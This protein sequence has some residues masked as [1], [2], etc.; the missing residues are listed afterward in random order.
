MT[1][2]ELIKHWRER[3][4]ELLGPGFSNDVLHTVETLQDCA[5]ELEAALAAQQDQGKVPRA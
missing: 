1:P 3:A 2:E 4:E 5:D